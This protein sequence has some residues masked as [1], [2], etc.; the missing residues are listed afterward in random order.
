MMVAYEQNKNRYRRAILLSLILILSFGLRTANLGGK[1]FY[2]DE[3][4]SYNRASQQFME[5]IRDLVGSSP[6]LPLYESI[7]HFWLKLGK[8]EVF[9][10][11]PSVLFGIATILL[12]WGLLRILSCEKIA[13]LVAMLLAISPFHIMFSRMAREYSLLCFLCTASTLLFVMLLK[14]KKTDAKKLLWVYYFIVTLLLIYTHYYAWIFIFSQNIYFLATKSRHKHLLKPWFFLQIILALLILPWFLV[15]LSFLLRG[16][17]YLKTYY[18][19]IFGRCVKLIFTQFVFCLGLTVSPWNLKI[20]IP[21]FIAF[22]MAFTLGMAKLLRDC[23]R[24]KNSQLLILILFLIPVLVE[25]FIPACAPRQIISSLPF[26]FAIIAVG[27][28]K[29]RPKL[30]S[31]VICV[32]IFLTSLFSI[33]N[34]FTGSQFIDVDMVTPWNKITQDIADS[35]HNTDNIV[36]ITTYSGNF[37]HYY[38]GHAGVIYQIPDLGNKKH[39]ELYKEK[40]DIKPIKGC[41]HVKEIVVNSQRTWIL[42]ACSRSMSK[43][44]ELW[45]KQKNAR[46]VGKYQ[47]EEHT[48]KGLK[49]GWANRKKYKSYIYRLYL[50]EKP[51][52]L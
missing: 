1:C 47:L 41:E 44:V 4:E 9:T 46:E 43:P 3:F 24:N 27:I 23:I 26:L 25:A 45:L 2:C 38:K 40:F 34:Y 15:N 22:S 36:L 10:R 28:I 31:I 20:V 50:Y 13:F 21:A 12:T 37:Y 48:L 35:V 14:K 16:E 11:M 39:P 8:S 29:M 32:I 52:K 49:E 42:V 18:C 7:L 17:G 51:D 19:S 30:L 6:H 5:V 33:K